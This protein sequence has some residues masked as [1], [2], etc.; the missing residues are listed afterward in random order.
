MEDEILK[1]EK[2]EHG[3]IIQILLLPYW[4]LNVFA[5]NCQD[6]D[7]CLAVKKKDMTLQLHTIHDEECWDTFT[8]INLSSTHWK[9]ERKEHKI[10]K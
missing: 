2:Q 8:I 7:W 1:I 10:Y 5:M 9:G 3:N 6:D 4:Y